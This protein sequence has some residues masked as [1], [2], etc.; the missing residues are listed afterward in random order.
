MSERAVGTVEHVAVSGIYCETHELM[1]VNLLGAADLC[2]HASAM[3]EV[4]VKQRKTAQ[5]L[6]Q[7]HH[8]GERSRRTRAQSFRADAKRYSIVALDSIGTY[9]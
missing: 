5:P 9:R 2:D 3:L 6:D 4:D 8:A 1:W 7:T